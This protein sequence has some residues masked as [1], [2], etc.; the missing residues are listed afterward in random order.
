MMQVEFF[1]DAQSL[2]LAT[3]T[4]FEVHWV[5]T[6][7][8]EYALTAVATDDNGAS[9]TSTV[10]TITAVPALQLTNQTIIR[11]GAAWHYQDNGLDPGAGWMAHGHDTSS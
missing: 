9:S 11:T 3:Q 7:P 6:E 8:R 1:A 10:N 4:P 2:G 5:P